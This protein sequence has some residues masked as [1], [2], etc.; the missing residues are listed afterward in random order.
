MREQYKDIIKD[1]LTIPPG[2]VDVRRWRKHM[3][4]EQDR[5]KKLKQESDEFK[6]QQDEIQS[7]KDNLLEKQHKRYVDILKNQEQKINDKLNKINNPYC[8]ICN[9][10]SIK[11]LLSQDHDH[12]CCIEGTGCSKCK[13]GLICNKC[14]IALG[15]VNDDTTI[16]QNMIKYI[17]HY[18]Q[19]KHLNTKED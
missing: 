14:N 13:R 12:T 9:K 1:N 17:E 19:Q 3:E 7:K 18:A 8:V 2:I 10:K 16:L 5:I 4:Q 6:K 15:M 11:R